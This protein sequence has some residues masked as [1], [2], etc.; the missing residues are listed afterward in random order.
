MTKETVLA[1]LQK[2]ASRHQVDPEWLS[3]GLTYLAF[4]AFA[5]FICS[6]AEVLQY[7][8]SEK[9][10]SQLSEVQ[11]SLAFL[12][13]ALLEGD[14]DVHD[15]VYDCMEHLAGCEWLDQLKKYFGPELEALWARHF[16]NR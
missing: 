5:R 4:G 7:V 2:A 13:R 11:V 9:E 16:Q 3:D 15:L 10:T 1:E 12:E 14:Q 8:S 6:E